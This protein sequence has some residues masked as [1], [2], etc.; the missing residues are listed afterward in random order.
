MSI[1]ETRKKRYSWGGGVL[2][3]GLVAGGKDGHRRLLLLL[4]LMPVRA[5]VIVVVGSFLIIVLITVLRSSTTSDWLEGLLLAEG[6]VLSL[7]RRSLRSVHV[8]C[9]N[10]LSVLLLVV[11]RSRP[12]VTHAVL[13]DGWG[14][15]GQGPETTLCGWGRDHRLLVL[16]LGE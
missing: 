7:H 16:L 2:L 5:V 12:G 3:G 9:G 6:V 8:I 4:L 11:R 14:R 10:H 1:D 15:Q 13:L